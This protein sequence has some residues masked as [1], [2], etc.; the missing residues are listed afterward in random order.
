MVVSSD[1]SADI[2][3]GNVAVSS[4]IE[5]GSKVP[6]PLLVEIGES[7]EGVQEAG[8]DG[9]QVCAIAGFL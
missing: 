3:V 8:G 9:T 5:K 4:T 7:S 1:I 6:L 2:V